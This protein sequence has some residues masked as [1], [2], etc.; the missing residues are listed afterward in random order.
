M[1]AGQS[2][3][4]G[5]EH[6][7]DLCF[8]FAF[9]ARLP[10]PQL[11]LPNTA[12]PNTFHPSLLHAHSSAFTPWQLETPPP[13]L[14]PHLTAPLTRQSIPMSRGPLTSFVNAIIW[15]I[16]YMNARCMFLPYL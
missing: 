13:S 12:H 16:L 6:T 2:A 15:P 1:H 11:Q 4:R 9:H 7:G 3:E 5:A 10:T 8:C 14:P